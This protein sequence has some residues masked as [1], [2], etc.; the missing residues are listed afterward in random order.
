MEVIT[1]TI[2]EIDADGTLTI[3]AAL[4]SVERAVLRGY[5]NVE[6]GLGDGRTISPEQRRLTYKL[7]HA[8]AE[9]QGECD[10]ATKAEMKLD[11]IINRQRSMA[12]RMFS[13][14]DCDMTTA[15]EFITYLI[16]F[17][18]MY[19][20]Y[21]DFR[22]YDENID[23]TR[24]VYACLM[25]RKCAVCGREGVDLHHVDSVGMRSRKEINQLGMRVMSLCREHHSEWHELGPERF[26]AKYHLEGIPLTKEIGRVYHLNKRNL[27]EA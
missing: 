6:R 12:R 1:G 23:I 14:S 26:N 22:P 10:E 21:L 5:K 20:V 15:R 2:T 3:K 11:F 18:V 8:I 4:P 19:G 17:I 16:D 9:W 25:N 27:G 13:L 24:Y 7:L